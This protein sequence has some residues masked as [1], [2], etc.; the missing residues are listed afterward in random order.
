MATVKSTL[1]PSYSNW[2]IEQLP[3]LSSRQQDL[4]K[5]VGINT[6]EQLLKTASTAQR[7]Q[8]LSNQLQLH[9]NY[10][11]KWVAMAEL[12]C[13]PSVGCEYCGLILHAGIP[14]VAQLAQTPVPRLHRQILRLQVA[15]LQRRDL[16][17]SVD[18]MQIWIQQAKLLTRQ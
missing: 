6:T 12:A 5:A 3:G 2:S 7:K 14:S 10:I 15:N 18:Q 8:K 4:L 13:I 9:L 1:F 11:K 17:P 16:C